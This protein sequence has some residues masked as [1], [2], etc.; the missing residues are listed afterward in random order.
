[1]TGG[2]TSGRVMSARSS[3]LPGTSARASTQA[4]GTPSTRQTAV[5]STAETRDRRSASST[6]GSDRCVPRSLHGVRT[7]RPTSGRSR[8]AA[9][10]AAGT[11]NTGG[12][13]LPRVRTVSGEL[14]AGCS[15]RLTPRFTEDVVDKGL[16]TGRVRR[17]RQQDQRVVGDPL[18]RLREVEALDGTTGGPDIG[19]ID[20]GGVDLTECDL[21][22]R[23]PDVLLEGVRSRRETGGLEDP[24]G[25]GPARHLLGA[26]RDRE[27]LV[28][29]VL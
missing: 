20:Q 19:A 21:G 8:K 25:R 17:V 15:Q 23:G 27:V 18:P 14:K 4:S 2:R 28:G 13:P 22:Q 24:D 9:A 5:A 29:Q 1:T 3:R 11:S 12:M 6:A 10:S 7:S 26:Q 16:G